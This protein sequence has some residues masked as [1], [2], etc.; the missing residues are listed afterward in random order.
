MVRLFLILAVLILWRPCAADDDYQTVDRIVAVVDNEIVLASDVRN[1]MTFQLLQLG[2]DPKRLTPSELNDYARKTLDILIR[3]KIL[4]YKAKKDTLEV[5][6]EQ[7]EQ[8]VRQQIRD[9]RERHPDFEDLLKSQ[10][11]TERELRDR[12]RKQLKE[13]FLSQKV[14]QKLRSEVEA[15]YRDIQAYREAYRDS[16]P[17]EISISH[18]LIWP[19]AGKE[20]MEAAREKIESLLRRAKAGEDFALL[21]RDYSEDPGSARSGGDL[22][23]FGKGTMAPEFEAAAFAMA[24]G[25]I[26]DV[27]E[28]PFGF[29]IIK[30]ESNTG[31]EV[32]AR[33]MLIKF[34]DPTEEEGEKAYGFAK[35]L[36]ERA[37]AGESFREL[38]KQYSDD[39]NTAADGGF[40]NFYSRDD[41]PPAF[42][43]EVPTM[44][45]GDVAG[46][47][48][49]E[50]GWHVFKI[51][52]DRRT[53]ENLILQKKLNSLFEKTIE[54]TRA[55]LY[56]DI[57]TDEE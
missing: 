45:L 57:R 15:S 10:N 43:K 53:I 23:S 16:L 25:D 38:A 5:E 40:L 55:K 8:A 39:K 24:P 34:P 13:Q 30:C 4:L 3:S 6:P 20:K 12:Y 42:A 54:E 17:A 2:K 14:Q 31:E 18:I 52:D 1:E 41:P 51:D 26:S 37:Q 35:E 29:H 19:K 28:S 27:V 22:G 56:V 7:V 36:K 48:K 32:R 11:T 44:R 33:H 47:V 50:F 49:S 9:L 21:A 46:P